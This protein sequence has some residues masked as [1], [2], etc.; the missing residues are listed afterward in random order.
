M[1]FSLFERKKANSALVTRQYEAITESAR[2]PVFYRDMNVPD[3][4]MGRFEMIT[5]HMVLYFR[6]SRDAGPT[7]R[8]VAQ[9][10]IE[11]FFEDIDHSMRELGIGDAGVPKRMKKI[12]RMFYGRADSYEAA[13]AADDREALAAALARN[14]HPATPPPTAPSMQALA[15]H[16]FRVDRA[17]ANV[18]QAEY[19]G[20]TVHFPPAPV[21]TE[22]R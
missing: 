17:L 7:A 12:G 21:L 5:L 11:A 18:A 20:G 13:L 2:Q 6:H 9:E 22:E 16:A 15:E 1:I 8:L 14:I 3:T 10:I 19:E 4:V